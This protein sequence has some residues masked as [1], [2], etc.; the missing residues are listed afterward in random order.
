MPSIYIFILDIIYNFYIFYWMDEFEYVQLVIVTCM[1]VTVVLD[2][3]LYL[4]S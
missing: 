2:K 1:R 3:Q 4:L